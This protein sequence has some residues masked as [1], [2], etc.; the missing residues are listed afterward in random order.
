MALHHSPHTQSG[1]DT[2]VP[3][4]ANLFCETTVFVSLKMR[5]SKSATPDTDLGFSPNPPDC[6]IMPSF[7]SRKS[8][9]HDFQRRSVALVFGE[10]PR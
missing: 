5:M 1:P 9:A 6:V 8:G 10:E 3:R 7:R 2:T 4:A